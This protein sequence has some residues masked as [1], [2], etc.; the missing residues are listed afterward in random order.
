MVS[1][2]C[3][4]LRVLSELFGVSF[5]LCR[6]VKSLALF[7]CLNECLSTFFPPFVERTALSPTEQSWHPFWN[8]LT[9]CGG[10]ITSPEFSPLVCVSE[11]LPAL[12]CLHYWKFVDLKSGSYETSDFIFFKIFWLGAGGMFLEVPVTFGMDFS[13]SAKDIILLGSLKKGPHFFPIHK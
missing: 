12:H 9:V 1:L 10:F 7:F 2:L 3:S 11:L 5:C 6:E 8:H 13:I 4:L